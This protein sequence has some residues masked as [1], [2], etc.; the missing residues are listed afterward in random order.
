MPWLDL[1][2]YETVRRKEERSGQVSPER[3]PVKVSAMQRIPA[4]PHIVP[5]KRCA[6]IPSLRD[7]APC[8]RLDGDTLRGKVGTLALP[9]RRH[10]SPLSMKVDPH[11]SWVLV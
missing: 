11:R 3:V 8:V 10:R 1:A 9:E 2:D 4:C 5:R 7:D 6:R